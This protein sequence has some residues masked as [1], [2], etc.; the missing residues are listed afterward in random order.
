MTKEIASDNIEY[1]GRLSQVGIYFKKFLRMFVYQNDWKVLPIGAI[2]AA[3]VVFVVG[4]NMFVTQ[5]GTK[6]GTFALTCAC[7]WSGFF[8]SI[9]V[10]CRERDIVK[11][12]HRSGMHVS[13]YIVA[14]MLYQMI[15]CFLQTLVTLLICYIARVQIPGPGIVTPWGVLDFGITILL[16]IYAA[17]IMALMVSCLVKTTTTAMTVMPFLLIFQ[18]IFSG[19]FFELGAADF[20]KVT[21]ISHW[22]MDS[23]STIGRYNE[24]PMVTLWNTLVSFKDIEVEGT[25]PLL[26]A[27]Q[28]IE[29]N[30]MRDEFLLWSGQNNMNPSYEAVASN[31]WPAW[32]AIVL[33][34]VLFAVV[35]IIALKLIDRDKR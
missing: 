34:I 31:V 1:S 8:N 14:H 26:Y 11:R 5:E 7:I 3:L 33:M 4:S 6:M 18:L 19:G 28:Q 21:T 30:D 16:V 35:A 24:Q 10:V 25:K 15:L 32:L 13:S 20:L 17:D 9:Q 2:I 23:L 22:G 27:L 12:E 29:Q